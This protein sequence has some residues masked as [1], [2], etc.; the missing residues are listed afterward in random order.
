[1]CARG[2]GGAGWAAVTAPPELDRPAATRRPDWSFARRPRWVVGSVVCLLLVILFAN[3]GMWQLRR[4]TERA[5]LNALLAER[6]TAGAVPLAEAL[7]GGVDAAR[8][9]PVTVAGSYATEREV[10]VGPVSRDGRPGYGVLTPLVLEDGT[11]LWVDRGS[12]PFAL[13]EPP[14]AEAAPPSPEVTVTGLLLASVD[15]GGAEVVRP[16]GSLRVLGRPDVARLAE[17]TGIPTVPLYL[18]LATQDP[19]QAGE[20]PRP[21]DPP[22]FGD[23]G[24]H[25]SYAAQ[26]FIFAAIGALGWPLLL[27][28]TAR[29]PARARQERRRGA[30][31]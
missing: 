24:P 17:R 4:H 28:R 10:L 2:A 5:Q 14:L 30:S 1:V 21:T 9:R 29:D 18:Q 27:W 8:Y 20:M 3:L 13:D 12:V 15:A 25:R 23:A 7:S 6:T 16:D 11:D 22:G 19:P 26:W 31:K